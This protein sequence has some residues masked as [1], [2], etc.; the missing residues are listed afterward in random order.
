M[1]LIIGIVLSIISLFLYRN[2]ILYLI[3]F[4]FY[5]VLFGFNNFNPDYSTYSNIYKL[6]RLGVYDGKLADSGYMFL[7]SVAHSFNLSFE[8]FYICF[9]I[10]SVIML[11]IVIYK[12]SN[13]RNLVC[14][15]ILLYPFTIS[16]VQ[17][18]FF[19]ASLIVLI[20]IIFLEKD[21]KYSNF[22]FL[23]TLIIASTIHFSSILYSVYFLA[24]LKSFKKIYFSLLLGL[25]SI[26]VFYQGITIINFTPLLDA[27]NKYFLSSLEFKGIVFVSRVIFFRLGI[28][29]GIHILIKYFKHNFSEKDIYLAKII[30]I[31]MTVTMFFE[32]INSEFERFSRIGFILLYILIFNVCIKMKLIGNRVAVIGLF[33]IFIFLY[34]GFQYFFRSSNGVLFYEAVFKDIFEHN[35]LVN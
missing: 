15:P 26:I 34:V 25:L 9:A 24:N 7:M 2:K 29:S 21:K 27:I 5:F 22:I 32:F 14:I 11:F 28:V 20:G 6:V 19:L 1:L 31:T 23:G 3:W 16:V 33:S 10:V 4:L 8:Q 35:S 13:Y 30:N 12:F 17:M 18:R